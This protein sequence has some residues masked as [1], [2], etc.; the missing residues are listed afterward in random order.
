MEAEAR[1]FRARRFARLQERV[2]RG[3]VDFVPS[4]MILVIAGSLFGS[5]SERV[6]DAFAVRVRRVIVDALLDLVAGN[7]G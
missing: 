3:D 7:A 4:T 6:A 2:L 1:N 5:S